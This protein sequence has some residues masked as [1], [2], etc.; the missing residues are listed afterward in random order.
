MIIPKKKFKEIK[1]ELLKLDEQV[2][3]LHKK[4]HE[5]YTQEV[6]EERE[7]VKEF[8]A[9]YEELLREETEELKKRL[10]EEVE[11]EI[12]TN[13][14][15]KPQA[16]FKLLNAKITCLLDK[17]YVVWHK[18][19]YCGDWVY[20]LDWKEIGEYDNWKDAKRKMQEIVYSMRE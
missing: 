10:P 12:G 8:L 6:E 19:E 14:Y 9:D 20:V 2:S 1:E 18:I 7:K 15:G 5:R 11:W 17:K 4:E 13:S 16:V 3:E